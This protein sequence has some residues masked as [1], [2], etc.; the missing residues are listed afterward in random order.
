MPSRSSDYGSAVQSAALDPSAARVT[1]SHH[2]VRR[3]AEHEAGTMSDQSAAGT[4]ALRSAT[5]SFWTDC[6]TAW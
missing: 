4:F 2:Q 6:G 5:I 3:I 1:T